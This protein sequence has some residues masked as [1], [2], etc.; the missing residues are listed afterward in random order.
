[1]DARAVER[2]IEQ[3]FG[4]LDV[5]GAAIVRA[6]TLDE[7]LETT[8]RLV[9]A[10]EQERAEGRIAGFTALSTFLPSERTVAERE[11]R[12]RALP[13]EAAAS[14]LVSALER[15]GFRTAPFAA[16]VEELR[17]GP[18]PRDVEALL[19]GPLASIAGV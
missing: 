1:G 7:A 16:F 19:A 8:E 3:A 2:A 11:E 18:R 10:L 4:A 15:H 17:R 12:F 9:A 14:A 13:R 5:G 6:A